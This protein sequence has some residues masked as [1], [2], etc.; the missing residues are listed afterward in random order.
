MNIK[1]QKAFTLI[2][3][4]VA[5]TLMS[6]LIMV[7]FGG[8]RAGVRSWQASETYIND[9]EEPRQLSALLY[10][11]LGQIVPIA[12]GGAGVFQTMA[13]ETGVERI[14]YAA[15]LAMSVGN[16]HYLFEMVNNYEGRGG[17]WARFAPIVEGL[18]AEDILAA[19]PYTQVSKE[20]TVQFSYFYRDEWLDQVPEGELPQL[21]SVRLTA[22]DKQWPSMVFAINTLGS[23]L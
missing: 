13:F 20:W 6:L 22:A 12:L 3:T 17:I 7:L 1:Q 2:E 19:A 4:L 15:P 5:L 16:T 8:F 10:R 9:T 18:P 11:H 14:R 23:N 21:V